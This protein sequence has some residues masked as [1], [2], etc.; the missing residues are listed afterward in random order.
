MKCSAVDEV[1]NEAA[2]G[3]ER[4]CWSVGSA[5]R[6]RR[7][8]SCGLQ[9][10]AIEQTIVWQLW[11]ER[12]GRHCSQQIITNTMCAAYSPTEYFSRMHSI[13]FKL[14]APHFVSHERRMQWRFECHYFG[15]IL[16]AGNCENGGHSRGFCSGPT[17]DASA[18]NVFPPT[19]SLQHSQ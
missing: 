19:R 13:W 4:F 8:K 15:T 6:R 11:C 2:G 3:E 5:M 18:E 7:K 9:F 12:F 17:T 16:T 10:W 14:I 1:L